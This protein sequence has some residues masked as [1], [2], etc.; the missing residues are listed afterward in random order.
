QAGDLSISLLSY[1]G[2]AGSWEATWQALSR[3][4]AYVVPPASETEESP[5]KSC[6]G[7]IT[8]RVAAAPGVAGVAAA[9]GEAAVVRGDAAGRVAG[10]AASARPTSRR[11]CGAARTASGGYCPAA[12]AAAAAWC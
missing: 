2:L 12:S 1:K 3:L 6:R 11:F 8:R 5:D 4:I 9:A 7:N 10:A